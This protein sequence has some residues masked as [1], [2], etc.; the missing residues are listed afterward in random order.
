MSVLTNV[1][2]SGGYL[3]PPVESAAV[4]AHR[5]YRATKIFGALDG[6]RALCCLGVLKE[7]SKL[8]LGIPAFDHGDLGVD[9]FFAISGFLIV[10]LLTRERE[11]RTDISLRN[12]YARRTLRIFPIYYLTILSATLFYL[13]IRPWKPAGWEFYHWT[14][15][16]LLT[17]TQDVVLLN[18]G[19]FFHTWSLAMEEQFYLLWPT[20]ERFLSRPWR[21]V[22]L[23]AV[24]ATSQAVNF[25]FFDS[26]IVRLY[27][28]PIAL[29]MPIFKITFTPIALGVIL[30]YLLHDRR[31][32]TILYRVLGGR[33]AFLPV[34]A[35]LFAVLQIAPG[36]LSGWPH[37]TAQLTLV[38]LLGSLVIRSDHH[39]MTFLKFPLLVRLGITSYGIYLYHVF[40]IAFIKGGAHALHVAIPPPVL[41][42]VVTALTAGVAQVS[43]RFVEQPLLRLRARFQG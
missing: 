28:N 15:L 27:G 23:G 16:G 39:A 17:Y 30:A 13:A 31:S 2:V 4:A 11:R 18:L 10:T 9:M 21:W 3:G 40:M 24:I 35:V 20:A 8:V 32:F 37:L 41:F 6:I 43:F 1:E 14:F 7:H 5:A 34:L 36:D 42:L 33:F 22:A 12:F 38:V 26:L 19:D 29:K 25:G